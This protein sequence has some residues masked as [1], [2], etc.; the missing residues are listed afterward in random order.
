MS[1]LSQLEL[2][3]EKFEAEAEQIGIELSEKRIKIVDEIEKLEADFLRKVKGNFRG[4][5][6]NVQT[7]N[8]GLEVRLGEGDK[9]FDSHVMVHYSKSDY[10]CA[11]SFI[12]SEL[13]AKL[14]DLYIEY[15]GEL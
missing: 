10:H 13:G 15:F 9:A 4:V 1:K 2:R 7:T 6:V 3:K 8:L 12:T 14:R 5:K 11:D